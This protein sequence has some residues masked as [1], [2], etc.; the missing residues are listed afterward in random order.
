M[1][2][3]ILRNVAT[4]V[5]FLAPAAAALAADPAA[6]SAA[7]GARTYAI[8]SLIGDQFSVVS[9]RPDVGTRL[10]PNERTTLPV[11]DAVFDR[12]AAAAVEKLLRDARPGTPVLT[13]L[14]RD[15]RLFALQDKLLQES[16]E[17]H[18][19]RIALRDLLAK[20]GATDLILVTKHRGEPQFEVVT[21]LI[22]AGGWLSGIGFYV[23]S[24]RRMF[25]T[26]H[27]MTGEGFLAPYAYLA[28]SLLDL[29]SMRVVKSK[30]GLK[31]TMALPQDKHA[32]AHSWDAMTAKEKVD[33]LEFVIRKA[34]ES[35]MAGLA[36][37]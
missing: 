4:F 24:E 36:L 6:P 17:S 11:P 29:G 30:P 2:L 25:N 14:I 22:S 7:A 16:G 33:A 37:P 31:T 10:D 9:R 12:V 21:G 19:M 15:P 18:D 35:G 23:D 28:V 13:A 27:R 1:N 26:E 34:V 8:V 20:A 5:V 32:A 3:S